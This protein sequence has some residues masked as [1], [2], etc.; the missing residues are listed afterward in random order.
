MSEKLIDGCIKGSIQLAEQILDG[1]S[2]LAFN[3]Y[4]QDMSPDW[5]EVY[6]A[7]VQI[8]IAR[9]YGPTEYGQ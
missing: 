2:E 1:V 5:Q 3:Q 8:F 4:D 7:A 6:K 9:M